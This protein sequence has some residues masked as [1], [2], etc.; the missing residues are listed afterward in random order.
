MITPNGLFECDKRHHLSGIPPTSK[1]R[2]K[3][4]HSS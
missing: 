1:V 3:W 2:S 4:L